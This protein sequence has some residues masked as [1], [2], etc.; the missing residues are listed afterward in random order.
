MGPKRFASKIVAKYDFVLFSC[1]FKKGAKKLLEGRRS[2]K[3]SAPTLNISHYGNME[4]RLSITDLN[5][6]KS[7]KVVLPN[8]KRISNNIIRFTREKIRQDIFGGISSQ[9]VVQSFRLGNEM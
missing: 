4:K 6:L 2:L 9:V 7:Q 3:L 8:W 1:M 5:Y